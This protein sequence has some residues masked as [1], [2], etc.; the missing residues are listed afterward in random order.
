[1]SMLIPSMS[2]E[3][4]R[5]RGE[6]QQARRDVEDAIARAEAAEKRA[7]SAEAKLAQVA[8]VPYVWDEARKEYIVHADMLDAAVR[9]ESAVTCCDRGGVA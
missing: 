4:L 5:L 6:L 8:D 2:A 9:G 3:V 7:A 1:M